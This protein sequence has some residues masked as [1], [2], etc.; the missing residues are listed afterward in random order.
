MNTTET[1]TFQAEINQLL[2]LIIN[3]FYTKKE[4]FIRELV[5]NSSDAL[6][7]LKYNLLSNNESC[8]DTELRIDIIPNKDT[9]TLCIQDTGI[10]MTKDEL[11]KN[12]GTIAHSGTKAFI[13]SMKQQSD[14]SLIGQFGVGFY[15]AF[16]VADKVTVISRGY[17]QDV[18]YEWSSNASGTFNIREIDAQDPNYILHG[19]KLL[20]TLKEDQKEFLE[21]ATIKNVIK[22]HSDFIIYPIHLH[23]LREVKDAPV[24][25]ETKDKDEVDIKVDDK[26]DAKADD[27]KADD[28]KADDAKT[29]DA[30]TDDAKAE[31]AKADNANADD[32]KA[33]DAKADDAKADD[34]KADDAK[35]DDA[36]AEKKMKVESEVINQTKSLWL[37]DP[38][39]VTHEE[40]ATFYKS[41]S[42]DWEEHLCVKHFSTEGQVEYKAILF[43][44][45]KAPFDLFDIKKK[46]TNIRLYVKHVLV[47]DDC[48]EI[49]PEWLGF[50]KGIV[51][52]NDLPLNI[53]R[54]CLQQNKIMKVIHKNLVKKCIEMFTSL[55]EKKD[56][57]KTFYSQY[58]KSLKLG[59]HEDTNN[60]DKLIEL[61]RFSNYK[62]KDPN[63]QISLEEYVDQMKDGQE[64]IY[65]ITGDSED[66]LR[67]SPFI[68][69]C[70]KN[71]YDVLFMTDPMDEYMMQQLKDYK[72]KKFVCLSKEGFKCNVSE[73][74]KKNIEEIKASYVKTIQ[75]MKDI[76]GN[77]VENIIVSERLTDTPCVLVT[78]EYGWSA[79]MER[80][81]KAQALR[82]T[83][84]AAYMA[85]RKILEINPTDSIIKLIKQK[86]DDDVVDK[87]TSDMIHL[88][89]ESTL[90]ASGFTL[91]NVG[92]YTKKIFQI[93]RM[94]VGIEDDAES[95]IVDKT[96]ATTEVN[97]DNKM[98]SVD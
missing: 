53:S 7:K 88:L 3:T 60:R 23:V 26:D 89:Y 13:E 31:D 50:V 8:G 45:K 84:T 70:V 46:K 32:A 2:T 5:S 39:K 1:F 61:L 76:L 40:Y 36:T 90:L 48:N 41:I 30:K 27:A 68:E 17:K 62:S 63:V 72:T 73:D 83:A 55:V 69:K 54:E 10:G 75:K 86:V 12:L 49:L 4:V 74:E 6:D 28:A 33:D 71:G 22:K 98:E 51:D 35:T 20:L 19:T 9:N 78:S 65:Y 29:D 59:I 95:P 25:T 67:S 96:N 97:D 42:S 58:A 91:S 56:D 38:S 79:N 16:L 18:C 24:A 14:V 66:N 11:I 82:D 77:K 37:T 47:V 15:S 52:S 93:I 92:D 21:E 87:S 44:P 94:G 80:I 34:A 64:S 43:C 57:Y 81:M 85:A